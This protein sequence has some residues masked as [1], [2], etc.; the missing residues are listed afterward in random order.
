MVEYGCIVDY[1][2]MVDSSWLNAIRL[3]HLN[4]PLFRRVVGLLNGYIRPFLQGN[5]IPFNGMFQ[6]YTCEYEIIFSY[7]HNSYFNIVVIKLV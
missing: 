1:D 3:V 5:E 7:S 4:R 2:Y 6:C